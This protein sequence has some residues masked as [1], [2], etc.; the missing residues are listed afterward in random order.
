MQVLSGARCIGAW[1]NTFRIKIGTRTTNA[2]ANARIVEL[3]S[4]GPRQCVQGYMKHNNETN[5]L[6]H[7]DKFCCVKEAS[8]L[9]MVRK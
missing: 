4:G 1:L 5:N 3:S 7:L 2:R 8:Y 6:A 9:R